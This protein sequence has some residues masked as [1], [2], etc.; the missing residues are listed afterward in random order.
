M[1][2]YT[3]KGSIYLT[4]LPGHFNKRHTRRTSALLYKGAAASTVPRPAVTA[5][6]MN[7]GISLLMTNVVL[8]IHSHVIL[9][10]KTDHCSPSKRGN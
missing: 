9:F 5:V 2:S 7:A 1:A 6:T 4:N 10:M 3:N 8:S